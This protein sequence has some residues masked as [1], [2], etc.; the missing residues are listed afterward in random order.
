M[1]RMEEKRVKKLKI[2]KR[3]AEEKM[4]RLYQGGCGGG[5]TARGGRSEH[6]KMEK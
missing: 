5:R 3:Q 6:G 2:G 1:H 4:E